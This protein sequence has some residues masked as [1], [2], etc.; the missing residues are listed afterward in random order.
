[1]ENKYVEPILTELGELHRVVSFTGA[2]TDVDGE[3]FN[4]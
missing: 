3:L 4:S 2:G 1:M